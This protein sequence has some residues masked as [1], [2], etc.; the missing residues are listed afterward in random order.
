MD[1]ATDDPHLP[2]LINLLTEYEMKLVNK[3]LEI[4]VDGIRLPY[5][6]GA[7]LCRGIR[8]RKFP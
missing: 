2:E 7:R 3:W 6:I 5:F 8:L 1:F 4:G